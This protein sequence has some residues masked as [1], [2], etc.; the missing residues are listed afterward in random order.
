VDTGEQWFTPEKQALY[1][2]LRDVN[3]QLGGDDTAAAILSEL[4]TAVREL[5]EAATE[6]APLAAAPTFLAAVLA[7]VEK[8]VTH[9]EQ[10]GSTIMGHSTGLARLD[11]LLGGLE[12]GR[13]TILQAAPGTG[14]TTLSNQIAYN[15]ASHGA[16]V[17]YISF[18][19]APQDLTLKTLCRL[20]GVSVSQASK[21]LIQSAKLEGA[22]RLFETQTRSLYY[23]AGNG[24]T[25]LESIRATLRTI[26]RTHPDAG[27]PVVFVDYL[28]QLARAATLGGREDIF[29]AVSHTSGQLSTLA[30]ETGAHVWAISSMNRES[31]K[32]AAAKNGLAS[33]KGSGDLEYD[34]AHVV[35]LNVDE[36]NQPPNS[37]TDCLSLGL[38]KNRFGPLGGMSLGRDRA[39]LRIAEVGHR[40]PNLSTGLGDRVRSNGGR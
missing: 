11:D 5:T 18:E 7:D 34:A 28:Q 27:Y 22:A 24:A 17:L 30:N 20:A 37:N 21:G 6:P 1:D 15:V 3:A 25:T 10:T 26:M 2:L 29:S 36:T 16:P 38:V 8:R 39:T 31:Y 12:P 40:G 4:S 9:F 23:V 35:A 14:K 19:N 32:N 33:G 13:V